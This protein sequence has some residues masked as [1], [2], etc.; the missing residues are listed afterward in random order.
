[1]THPLDLTSQ[2][3]DEKTPFPSSLSETPTQNQI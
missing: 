3:D 1:M 2:S